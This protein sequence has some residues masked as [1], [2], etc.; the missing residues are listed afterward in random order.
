MQI[1]AQEYRIL[2]LRKALQRTRGVP[3]SR[4]H[5]REGGMLGAYIFNKLPTRFEYSLQ[6]DESSPLGSLWM[7]PVMTRSAL[8]SVENFAM[9]SRAE[10]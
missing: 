1:P 5:P 7:L 8:I 2:H 3:I 9:R 6:F 10:V 4:A